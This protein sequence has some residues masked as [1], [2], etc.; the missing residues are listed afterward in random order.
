M[1]KRLVIFSDDELAFLIERFLES[2]EQLYTEQPNQE[3]KAMQ[4][5]K[6]NVQSKLYS[7]VIIDA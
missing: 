7:A 1:N 2:C 5:I 6:D 3:I 4:N